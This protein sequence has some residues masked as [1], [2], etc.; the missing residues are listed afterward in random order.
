ML[1][2]FANQGDN[3]VIDGTLTNTTLTVGTGSALGTVTL[4]S[5]GAIFG[6]K[7]VDQGSGLS[8]QGGTLGDVT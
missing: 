8:F 3:V 5:D 2:P 4:A 1:A 6:G 7:I